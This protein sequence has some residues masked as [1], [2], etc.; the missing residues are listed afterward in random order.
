MSKV[1]NADMPSMPQHGVQDENGTLVSIGEWSGEVGLT[2]LEHF[3][4][5]A[6]QGWLARCASAPHSAF[7]DPEQVAET[8]IEFAKALL[9]QLDQE[10][11]DE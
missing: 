3:A 11:G 5:L 8:S 6:M 7:I 10:K 1:N 9:A 4:G 2:K